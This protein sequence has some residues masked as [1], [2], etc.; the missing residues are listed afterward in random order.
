MND[1]SI[2]DSFRNQRAICEVI[3]VLTNGVVMRQADVYTVHRGTSRDSVDTK[4]L[5]FATK[6]MITPEISIESKN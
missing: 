4:E 5:Q 1:H 6:N 2:V 3:M